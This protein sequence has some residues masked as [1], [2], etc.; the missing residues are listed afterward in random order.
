MWPISE[1]FAALLADGHQ[2]TVKAEVLAGPDA[3]PI[4]VSTAFA[5]G[6]LDVSRQAIRRSGTA[7]FNGTT[8]ISDQGDT[9]IP[10]GP[11]S[12][13]APYGNELRLWYGLRFP[14]G[15]E[16]LIPVGTLRIT[17]VAV[18]HPYVTV[19]LADRAWVVQ[20]ARLEDSYSIPKGTNVGEAI[21]A[22][23]V[24]RFPQA[25]TN[26]VDGSDATGQLILDAQ[27]DPWEEL[28]QLAQGIGHQLYF[29]PLGTCVL[30]AEPDALD[31]APVW[32]YDGK[33]FGKIP[34]DPADWTNLALYDQ[35]H[36][37][38]T[39]GVYNAVVA[40]GES[41]DLA[42]PVRGVAVDSDPASPTL[43]GGKFGKRPL[44]WSSPLLLSAAQAEMAARTMLQKQVG[45]AESLRIPAAPHPALEC[46][47]P[48]QVIRPEL[49]I[50]TLHIVDHFTLPLRAAGGAQTIDTRVRRV[51]LGQ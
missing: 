45:L 18:R 13:L 31:V 3:D 28:Q 41:T 12:L 30:V 37:W 46:S 7:T 43:Y 21:R 14:D 47:D 48:I 36:A 9:L 6:S 22:L 10:T 29:D 51:V 25:T 23:L 27:S 33:P 34:Y 49:G 20:G 15:T 39:E 1:R 42:A 11:G 24:D 8:L 40:T 5:D 19:E 50:N 16:E 2:T 26:F 35:E 4:D 44:F 38:D 17:K 32:T